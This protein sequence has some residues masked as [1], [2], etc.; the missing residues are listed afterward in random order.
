MAGR[1]WARLAQPWFGR[2]RS[3]PHLAVDGE[4]LV[5]F[6]VL[7]GLHGSEGFELRRIVVTPDYRGAGRGRVLL[8]ALSTG[9]T[10]TTERKRF[11][12]T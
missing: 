12:W 11:G 8:Q 9:S 6:A 5:G 1:D 3:G 10:G 2:S 4:T 7:A